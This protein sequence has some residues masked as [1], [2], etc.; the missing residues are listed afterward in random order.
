MSEERWARIYPSQSSSSHRPK[1]PKMT[2]KR[3]LESPLPQLGLVLLQDW[4]PWRLD[5]NE[6]S[7]LRDKDMDGY[8]RLG[9][10]DPCV[11]SGAK[12]AAALASSWRSR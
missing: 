12:A 4:V 7:L 10:S 6:F 5:S 3:L 2:G 11:P 1:L 9:I 8:S